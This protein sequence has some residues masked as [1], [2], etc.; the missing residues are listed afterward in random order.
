MEITLVMRADFVAMPSLCRVT[1]SASSARIF[2]FLISAFRSPHVPPCSTS[3]CRCKVWVFLRVTLNRTFIATTAWIALRKMLATAASATVSNVVWMIGTKGRPER[4]NCS[5]EN[6][7]H[8]SARQMRMHRISPRS[9]IPCLT[10]RRPRWVYLPS[11]QRPRG[12][13]PPARSTGPVRAPNPTTLP[14]RIPTSPGWAT[15]MLNLGWPVLLH[16]SP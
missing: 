9:A 6:I 4:S 15:A 2:T 10:L 5:N 13:K 7:M 16:P 1:G 11:L 14:Y 8:R 12:P 3:L